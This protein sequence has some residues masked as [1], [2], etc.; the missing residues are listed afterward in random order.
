MLRNRFVR[1]AGTVTLLAGLLAA[2]G[3]AGAVAGLLTPAP[4]A[5]AAVQAAR[6]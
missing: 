2:N 5:A 3:A 1:I 6:P 4:H